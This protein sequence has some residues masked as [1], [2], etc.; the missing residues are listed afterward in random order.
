MLK[1]SY[2]RAWRHSGDITLQVLRSA[3]KILGRRRANPVPYV[4]HG[5]ILPEMGFRKNAG[6]GRVLRLFYLPPLCGDILETL[7]GVMDERDDL[8]T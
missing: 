4:C 1:Y 8:S 7:A 2:L 5:R 6:Q 3:M